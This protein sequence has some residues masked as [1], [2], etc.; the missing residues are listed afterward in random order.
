M[1]TSGHRASR[2]KNLYVELILDPEEATRGGLFPLQIPTEQA[3]RQCEGS[4]Y[5]GEL[6]C[7]TCHGRGRSVSY[8]EIE[9]SV[10]PGVTRGTEARISLGDIGLNGVDLIV[11]VTVS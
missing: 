5:Q 3:C 2:Q 9:V 4:G 1:F 8:H 11:L 6:S 10:P 7:Q